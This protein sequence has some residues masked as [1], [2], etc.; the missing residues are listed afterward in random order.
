[1]QAEDPVAELTMRLKSVGQAALEEIKAAPDSGV[2]EALRVKHLGKKSA[3]SELQKQMGQLA[4]EWRPRA[5]KVF[6]EMRQQLDEMLAERRGAFARSERNRKLTGEAID[7]TLPGR[8]LPNGHLHPLTQTT[9]EIVAIFTAMGFSVASGPDMEDEFHNFDA[10][11]IPANHPARDM[12]DTFWLQGGGVLRTHT[13]P[14]QIRAM[15][16]QKKPPIA[17]I[18]PGRVYRCDADQ[19][20]SPMFTQIEVLLVDEQ[21]R[22]S[23]L[24]GVLEN[25]IRRFFGEGRPFRLRPSFFPFTEPSAEV[26]IL[27]KKSDGSDSWLEV[28]GCG[29]VHPAVLES[30]GFDSTKYTGF[31]LGLG[32]ERF[33]MLRHGIHNIRHFS[34]NDLRFLNQF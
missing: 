25:L 1:M 8:K 29:M 10:L 12:Q 17:V 15:Q 22:M 9:R 11:N 28:L 31:A 19:T 13:S 18:A 7:V 32:V 2:L 33:A 20:H 27:W 5:G 6:N 23:D 26:D 14:V 30:V 24:K 16:A 4:A 3:L 21:V 34:E